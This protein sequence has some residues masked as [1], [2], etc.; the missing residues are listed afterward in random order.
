MFKNPK[1]VDDFGNRTCQKSTSQ[2]SERLSQAL[3]QHDREVLQKVFTLN[4][5][6]KEEGEADSE[7]QDF[8][9][10]LVFGFMNFFWWVKVIETL[11][12]SDNQSN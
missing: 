3:S 7:L 1:Q 9:V 5:H 4:A 2:S 8:L 11:G 12:Q 10:P 6:S